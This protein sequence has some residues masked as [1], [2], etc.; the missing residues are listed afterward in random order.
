MYVDDAFDVWSCAVDGRV[1][2]ETGNVNSKVCCACLN[3]VTLH[4][5]LDQR[6]G[7]DLV[8]KHTKWIEQKVLSILADS[9]LEY[10][11]EIC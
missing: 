2:H 6:G 1:Q 11:N 5:N 3:Y 10:S 9:N 8:V 7:S 4:I